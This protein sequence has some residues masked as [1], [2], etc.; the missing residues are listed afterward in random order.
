MGSYAHLAHPI[1]L[2]WRPLCLSVCNHTLR[3]TH[4][5]IISGMEMSYSQFL[6]AGKVTEG[7][8]RTGHASH[9]PMTDVSTHGLND[10]RKGINTPPIRNLWECPL[11][12]PLLWCPS[13]RVI[14]SF[15]PYAHAQGVLLWY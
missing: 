5:P 4:P 6:T 1:I 14:S 12:L 15:H 10:L 13:F 3:P 9:T 7:L 8:R 11:R 2:E